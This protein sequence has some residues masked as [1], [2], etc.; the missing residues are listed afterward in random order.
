MRR[1]G[2]IVTWIRLTGLF[3]V[4]L[5]ASGAAAQANESDG[6]IPFG[7]GRMF[8]ISRP[9]A[10]PSFVFGTMHVSDHEVLRLPG[11]VAR[12]FKTSRT[13]LVEADSGYEFAAELGRA[14]MLPAGTELSDV[15]DAPLYREV[16]TVAGHIGLPMGLADRLEPW[17][18]SFI[19]SRSGGKPMPRTGAPPV[20]DQALQNYALKY[21][22]PVVAL[23]R[24]AEI[25]EIFT[26]GFTEGDQIALLEAAVADAEDGEASYAALREAYLAGDLA[27][28]YTLEWQTTAAEA[29]DE[30]AFAERLHELLIV[31]RNQRWLPRMRGFLEAGGAFVAVGAA[32]LP[33]EDGIL[34][35]LETAGYQV[36]RVL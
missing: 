20:L 15:I 6:G 19:L 31:R 24:G 26:E 28:M 23:D 18:L 9:G 11:P 17:A 14:M 36:K 2:R 32:H 10:A 13:L 3:L 1:V 5:V 4:A 27:A 30:A 33:G 34:N 22:V 35:L 21:G 8:E 29:P 12:A 25:G 16:E 7:K